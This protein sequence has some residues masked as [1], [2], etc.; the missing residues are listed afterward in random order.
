MTRNDFQK[1]AFSGVLLDG[2]FGTELAKRGMPEGVSPELWA[3]ENFDATAEILRAYRAAGS[4]LL[5]APTFGGNRLKLANFHLENRVAEINRELVRRAKETIPDA[6]IFGDVSSTG[7]FI[8][9][10]GKLDFDEAVDVFREEISALISGGADGIVIETMMDLQESR[11][12]L[13]ALRE[14]APDLPGIV[15]MTF[16]SSM[17]SLTGVDPVSALVTLQALGADAFG[18]NC[19][20]GPQ[21]MVKLLTTLKPYAQ[22]PLVAKPNAGV[23]TL[24]NNQTFFPM[25]A[26]EFSSYAGAL[27]EA[28]A[29][30]LG[31][32]CGTTPEHI[33]Q[34]GV[35]MKKSTAFFRN[36]HPLRGVVASPSQ[37]CRLAP[38]EPF[39]VIGERINPTGKK[40]LQA[41]LREGKTEMVFDF[42]LQQTQAGAALLDVNMGLAGIDEKK[43][44]LQSLRQVIKASPLPVSIDSTDPETVE[45][46]LRFYPGRALLNS[47]S[48]EK[49]RLEKILPVA[50][51]Y[52]AMLI[53]LPLTDEGIP[54]TLDERIAV[55]EK[56]LA[57]IKKYGYTPQ[58]VALDALIMTISANNEAAEISLGLIAWAKAHHINTVCGLSNV[59]FGLPERQ[60]VNRTFLAMAIGC[61]LNSAIA[62][63][64][65]PETI[66]L[67]YAANALT[68]KD[69]H[70]KNFLARFAGRDSAAAPQ[71]AENLSAGEKVRRAIL[72]GNADGILPALE[73]ALTE[74]FSAAELL[75]E[76]LI[77]AINEVGAKYEKQEYFLPQL[78]ASAE[79]MQKGAAFLEPKLTVQCEKNPKARIVFATVK[80][81]IHD[82]GKNIVIV[83]LKNYGFDVIDLGKDVPPEVILDT[84]VRENVEIVALSALM[85]TTMKS[86]RQTI[87]LARQRGL[88]H[89]KFLVGG[90]VVDQLFADE[91]GAYYTADPMATVRTAQ[92]LLKVK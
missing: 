74:K 51:K 48:A 41:Q 47:I 45:A 21:D 56:L 62:N 2:A 84:A 18:C 76:V 83:M 17:R 4:Q 10:Y 32:C 69:L 39:A 81:D 70:Q 53:L 46:A 67:I 60:L 8:D 52:G 80:G 64:L 34:L 19:S 63:V 42:A 72:D 87:S 33:R 6:L 66:D 15:T 26:A 5:Y 68:G 22:I 78:I 29:A 73:A 82:I 43:M 85:T 75:N 44:M 38:E 7:N 57:E 89:L 65:F 30:L 50:A 58:D 91:I 13:I 88:N 12:A 24:R 90:A 16:E 11:A 20:T 55:V 27:V 59:S 9:P 86:I 31:G 3:L 77:P 92:E 37:F 54:D 35:E 25:D 1:F 71:K 49:S 14:V 36:A 79:A 61:G 28:G 23:P 40:A